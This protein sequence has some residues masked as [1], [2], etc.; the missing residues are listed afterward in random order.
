MVN[1][2]QIATFEGLG[3]GGRYTFVV[4][5]PPL[6]DLSVY[7]SNLYEYIETGDYDLEAKV[8]NRGTETI[9]SFDL[10]YSVDGGAT[11][12]HNVAS[13][14]IP[15]YSSITV[16]HSIAID[17][18]I[19]G[20]YNIKVWADNINIGNEDLYNVNDTLNKEIQVGPG[21]V[22]DIESYIDSPVLPTLIAGKGESIDDP[23][24]LDFHPTLTNMELWVVN[25]GTEGTGSNTTTIFNAGEEGQ[26]SINKED[27]N[28]WHFMSLTTG[29]AF[30]QNG[31]FGTSPGVYDANHDG[32]SAFTGPSLWSSDMAIYAEPSGGNGSH[33]DMLHASPYCQEMITMVMPLL[34]D[35]LTMKYKKILH[36]KL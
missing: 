25:R 22:N 34:E 24:D 28:A 18:P 33:L 30:S 27:G 12:T 3:L 11:E 10:N 31:N 1:G 14:S 26:T 35:I 15:N 16:E 20:M 13:V 7:E 4:E 8:F 21:T 2:Y 5:E 6:Y 32:G 9:T 29:I 17:L 19:E 23:T 36:R